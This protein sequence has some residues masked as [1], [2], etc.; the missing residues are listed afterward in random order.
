M[1]G[2]YGFRTRRSLLYFAEATYNANA[3]SRF[4]RLP[5]QNAPP[6]FSLSTQM[7]EPNP[8]IRVLV[9]VHFQAMTPYYSMP[10]VVQCS[11]R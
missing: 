3:R 7:Q 5:N 4:P 11:A 1:M 9:P 10:F 2:G 8:R 6:P